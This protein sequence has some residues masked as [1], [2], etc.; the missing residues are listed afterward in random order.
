MKHPRV[1]PVR[2]LLSATRV[3][4]PLLI[5]IG[6]VVAIVIGHGHTAAAGAGVGLLLVAITVWMINWMYRLSVASNRDRDREEDA[7]NYFDRHGR[8]PSE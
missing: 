6:G 8:W 7:R 4:L 2:L 3:W 1:S 5:A